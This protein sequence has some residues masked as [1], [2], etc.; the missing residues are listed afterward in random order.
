MRSNIVSR[1]RGA[2]PHSYSTLTR[3]GHEK[4]SFSTGKTFEYQ[5][6]DG[7]KFILLRRVVRTPFVAFV[8]CFD[9]DRYH[10][11]PR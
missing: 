10:I 4:N 2:L 5:A 3:P 11:S 1:S 6:Q 7:A 9:S 8:N